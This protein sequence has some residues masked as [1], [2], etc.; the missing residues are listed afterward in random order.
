MRD[1]LD[2]MNLAPP[3]L[4]PRHRMEE[5]LQ[6]RRVDEHWLDL[7]LDT[8]YDGVSHQS[9]YLRAVCGDADGARKSR[10]KEVSPTGGYFHKEEW[11]ATGE[12][13]V[14]PKGLPNAN[15]RRIQSYDRKEDTKGIHPTCPAAPHE[16]TFLETS[17]RM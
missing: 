4:L 1:G 11:M 7:L 5:R 17:M 6:G 14:T 12:K 15:C 8:C 9:T 10:H 16:G 3:P 2:G 13:T